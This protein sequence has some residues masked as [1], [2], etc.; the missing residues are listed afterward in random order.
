MSEGLKSFYDTRE[1]LEAWSILDVQTDEVVLVKGKKY[2]ITSSSDGVSGT[3]EEVEGQPL[4][5][6]SGCTPEV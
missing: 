5:S 1:A 3:I 6:S 4:S 2:K